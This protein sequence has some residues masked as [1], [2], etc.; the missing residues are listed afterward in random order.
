MAIAK[1]SG[2]QFRAARVLL[3]WTRDDLAVR[4]GLSRDVLRSWECSSDN[5]VP[6]QYVY[7]CKAIEVLERA[8]ARFNET[9][10]DRVPATPTITAPSE[11]L[12]A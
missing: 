6:A 4:S 2:N 7:L 10:V 9:G 11:G 3:G 1:I 5:I 12:S 8:G